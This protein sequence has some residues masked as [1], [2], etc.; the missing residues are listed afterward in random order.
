MI[1]A[2][3]SEI[4]PKPVHRR[5]YKA[6]I[7]SLVTSNQERM[8]NNSDAAVRFEIAVYNTYIEVGEL[9][10]GLDE[11]GSGAKLRP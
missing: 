8:L 9:P 2:R 11:W 1:Y 3:T 10:G 4:V 7:N 5:L 6:L